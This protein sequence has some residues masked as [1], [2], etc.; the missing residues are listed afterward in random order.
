MSNRQ[1]KMREGDIVVTRVGGHY[2]V[3]RL[4]ADGLIQT[5]LEQRR[6]R[7]DALNRA[8]QLAG[9]GHRVFILENSGSGAYRQFDCAET[10]ADSTDR[11]RSDG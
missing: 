2:A 9:T 5:P 6:R 10:P 11:G 3:G 4:N 7:T 8:C 1:P